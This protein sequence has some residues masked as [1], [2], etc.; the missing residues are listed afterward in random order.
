MRTS[1]S[2]FAITFYL[3]KDKMRKDSFTPIFCR[4]TIAGEAVS[5]NIHKDI[6]AELWD[7]ENHKARSK[8]REAI[9]VN[10]TL[11]LVVLSY[12]ICIGRYSRK[13]IM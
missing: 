2:T 5:F 4:I 10:Q 1:K 3:R 13:T 8:S 6:R 11:M 7:M 12:T 9:E